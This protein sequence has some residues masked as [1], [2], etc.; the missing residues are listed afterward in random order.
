MLRTAEKATPSARPKESSRHETEKAKPPRS[1]G[2]LSP[3]VGGSALSVSVVY[4]SLGRADWTIDLLGS[5]F[6]VVAPLILYG[7]FF[8]AEFA[9]FFWVAKIDVKFVEILRNRN[10]FVV[11]GRGFAAVSYCIGGEIL[12]RNFY[13]VSIIVKSKFYAVF[14]PWCRPLVIYGRRY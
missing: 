10:V 5:L 3:P 14:A 8:G 11:F 1:G 6:Q 7:A 4:F 2:T 9:H 12:D 13:I